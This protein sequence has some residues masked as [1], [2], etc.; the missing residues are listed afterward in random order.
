MQKI[1]IL[2][3]TFNHV[4]GY[5]QQTELVKTYHVISLAEITLVHYLQM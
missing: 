1:P 2:L 3:I 5:S 4:S